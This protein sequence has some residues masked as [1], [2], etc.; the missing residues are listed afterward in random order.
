[1][2]I[3]PNTCFELYKSGKRLS[4]KQAC[5]AKCADCTN[6]FADGRMDCLIPTCPIYPI[7]PYKDNKNAVLQTNRPKRV[8][9]P[10]HLAKMKNNRK[11]KAGNVP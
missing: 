2:S 6:S 5:L 8:L 7:M 10:E 9:S 4:F 1:M 11:N 3:N